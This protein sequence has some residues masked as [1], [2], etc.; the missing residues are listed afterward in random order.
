MKTSCATSSRRVMVFIH[1][2][3][4]LEGFAGDA[5]AG[6]VGGTGAPLGG[7][8][9]A[10]AAVAAAKSARPRS[11]GRRKED[12]QPVNTDKHGSKRVGLSAF[13]GGH[14]FSLPDSRGQFVPARTAVGAVRFLC[15]TGGLRCGERLDNRFTQ[16]CRWAGSL[17]L[18]AMTALAPVFSSVNASGSTILERSTMRALGSILRIRWMSSTP[19]IRGMR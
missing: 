7:G 14:C 16:R 11:A 3:T 13:I 2:R 15:E 18:L 12:R 6:L 10:V 1:L 5:A 17:E 19:F 9:W 8:V 4:T